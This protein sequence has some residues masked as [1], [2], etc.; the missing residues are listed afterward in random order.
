[1]NRIKII[2]IIMVVAA[3]SL[4][5]MPAAQGA[6]I[7]QEAPTITVVTPAA[8]VAGIPVSIQGSGF[9]PL[10]GLISKITFNGVDAGQAIYWSDALIWVIVPAT[11]TTGPVVVTTLLEASNPVQFTILEQPPAIPS[12]FAEGTT[13]SGFE[14]WL[15]LY[16]PF[17]VQ[18]T[19]TVTYLIADAA[20][21]IRYYNVPAHARVNI[22]VNSE[23]G[24][25]HDVSVS[26]TASERLFVE[27]PMYFNY[28]NKW[29][30]GHTTQ[31]A[32]ATSNTW[33]FAEG[34]T[35][36]GFEEWLCMGNPGITDANVNVTYIFSDGNSVTLP[37]T[38]PA[39]KRHTI[40]VNATIGPEADVA[41]KVESD[42]PLVAER[43]MYFNYRSN[44]NDGS[45]TLGARAP[46]T[47]WYFAEGTTRSGFEEWLCLAN[48][49]T[50]DATVH[51]TYHKAGAEDSD[52][53]IDVPAG[54]RRTI[55]VNA[56][57]GPEVDAAVKIDSDK[58]IIAERPMYFNYQNKWNGG[59]V[60]I[61]TNSTAGNWYL[62]EGTTRSGFEE[63]ICLLNPGELEAAIH[64]E[65]SFQDG[66]TQ[67]QDLLLMP[68]QRFSIL[69]NGVV[70]TGKDV[71][72]KIESDQ[73]IIAE[74]S[75]YFSYHE[76]WDGGSNAIGCVPPD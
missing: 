75:M 59:H 25:D 70:G 44:W 54:R 16:N 42:Q 3:L 67:D 61:G 69:V 24:S 45:I 22:Y 68:D 71:A 43:P 23:I 15:T 11:A 17:D 40:D 50:E 27:R 2:I 1:M 46:A 33:Y 6:G 41:L 55:D 39:F 29:S 7:A 53:Y 56:V 30:G 63:W 66:S 12:Y 20:N 21:R 32:L 37:Y 38:V 57:L 51:V 64:V 34:T 28:K 13:R 76:A 4:V 26:V 5:I 35:R 52:Q 60:S 14:E 19:A 47:T 31:P 58:A 9:G 48:P 74:R 18:V 72:V 65:Y 8:G 62:A 10:Q 73:G 49:Q 36:S